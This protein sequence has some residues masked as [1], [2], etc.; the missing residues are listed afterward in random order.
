MEFNETIVNILEAYGYWGILLL[1]LIEN[2]FPPIPSE[3][4]LTFSGFMTSY[5][6][7]QVSLVVLAATAGSVIG[8]CILYWLGLYVASNKAAV[9]LARW[10]KI[11]G[12]DARKAQG[13]FQ[14]YGNRTVFFCRFVPILRSIISVPAGMAKMPFATFI[15]FTAAGTCI[16]N[17]LLIVLGHVAGH[18]WDSVSHYFDIYS[19][20]VLI[21]ILILLAAICYFYL[22]HRISKSKDNPDEDN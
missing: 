11:E 1:I 20:M 3:V 19:R 5:G 10:L 17:T 18:G 4:I 7:L 21:A 22:Q 16:W 15:V 2:I 9:K 8:A 13:W 6:T 14:R 12:N